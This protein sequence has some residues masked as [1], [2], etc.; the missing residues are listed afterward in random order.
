MMPKLRAHTERF[1][2]DFK[3][4]GLE[5]PSERDIFLELLDGW[6]SATQIKMDDASCY[7][8]VCVC[9]WRGVVFFRCKGPLALSVVE[10]EN[11]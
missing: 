6:S 2:H 4:K 3:L 1:I 10:R 9:V 8:S 7:S 11:N 5:A